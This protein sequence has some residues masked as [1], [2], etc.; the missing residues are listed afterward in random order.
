MAPESG[1][2]LIQFAREP[3]AGAVKTRM[4][5]HLSAQAACDLH[6]ELVLWTTRSLLNANLGPVQLAVAGDA[7]HP[8]FECCQQLGVARLSQQRGADLGER[9]YN[10]L[11]DGLAEFEK[12]LLVGSDCPA[13]DRKYL[14]QA[15][16]GL[17]QSDIVLGP[18]SDG[19]YVLIGARRVSARLFAGVA[20]GG[21]AV[22]DE[23][24][25]RLRQLAWSWS[26]LP[27][28]PDIDRPEDLAVW[29][30]LRGS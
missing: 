15:V 4:I 25:R 12:V 9:M 3:V 14:V 11:A 6:S 26:E 22:F 1:C 27:V 13:I 21:A 29:A 30:A 16:A 24:T 23:T 10:A 5:P 17:E 19:G 20:W 18:A 28:L 8:V 7:T 2:L